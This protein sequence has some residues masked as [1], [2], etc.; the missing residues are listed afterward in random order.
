MVLDGTLL[1]PVSLELPSQGWHSTVHPW[2]SAQEPKGK[3]KG[4]WWET[5][6]S[7]STAT[8]LGC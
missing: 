5:G 4:G 8:T 2:V 1:Q 7:K 3:R 6:Q